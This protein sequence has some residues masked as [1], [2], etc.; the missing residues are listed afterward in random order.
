MRLSL[1]YKGQNHDY[2][3]TSTMSKAEQKSISATT[4]FFAELALWR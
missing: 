1:V 3:M 4:Q 2:N